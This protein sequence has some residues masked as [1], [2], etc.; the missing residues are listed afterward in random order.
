MSN[1]HSTGPVPHQLMRH[2]RSK[3]R[4][5][6]FPCDGLQTPNACH[7]APV[8]LQLVQEGGLPCALQTQHEELIALRDKAHN[9]GSLQ[10]EESFQLRVFSGGQ[11]LRKK[12]VC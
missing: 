2:V 3:R 11:G 4:R 7:S 5:R 12:R 10:V 6:S 8:D 1:P 9:D